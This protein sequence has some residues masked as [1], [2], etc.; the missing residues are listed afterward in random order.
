MARPR[1]AQAP[2][3]TALKSHQRGAAQYSKLI[4]KHQKSQSGNGVSINGAK[5]IRT[6][7]P[8]HAMKS[9][10]N[11]RSVATTAKT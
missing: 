11:L 10:Q 8:L 1:C 3:S 6:A 5:R 7:D 9:E 2:S 4:R